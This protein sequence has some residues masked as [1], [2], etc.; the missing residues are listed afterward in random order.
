MKYPFI[1]FVLLLSLNAYCA[2]YKNLNIYLDADQTNAI[3][4]GEAIYRGMLT[5]LSEHDYQIQGIPIAVI[6]KDHRG[7]SPRSLAHL[8]QFLKDDLAIS[9]F[10][11]LHSPPLLA[12]KQFINNN[13]IL[14]LDPWAAAGPITRTE[15]GNWIFRLSIDDSKAGGVITQ[16]ALNEGFK[17]PYLLL[18]DTGW[19]KSNHKT[20]NT[21]LTKHNHLPASVTWF[22][23]GLSLNNAKIILR[24]IANS[25]A[26]V[27]FLVA[28]S[29][30]GKTFANAMLE[31]PLKHQ[32]PIRSHWGITGGDFPE[33]IG[34]ENLKKIDLQFIQT[35]FSFFKPNDFSNKVLKQAQSIFDD[36]QGPADIKAPSGFIHG[37]DLMKLWIS[38]SNHIKFSG[39]IQ[40]DRLLLKQSLENLITPVQGLIKTYQHPFSNNPNDIDAHEALNASDFVMGF[41]DINGVIKNIE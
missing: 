19:G 30:E 25:G 28:N 29:P 3:T 40:Q 7:S 21:T 41:Y 15:G 11:G 8:K 31:L 17:F 10:S 33:S 1:F 9:V 34:P 26:D 13:K 18:E 20:I 32:L 4:S 14:M 12:N 22:K 16:S 6:K 39:N 23:W 27:I 35:S 5:A 2:P 37:Y 24:N 38:A 36:I